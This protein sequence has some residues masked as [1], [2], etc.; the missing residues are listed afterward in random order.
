MTVNSKNEEI[1][2]SFILKTTLLTLKTLTKFKDMI[3]WGI[4]RKK[5]I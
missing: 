3:I 2:K 4:K 5:K 1:K